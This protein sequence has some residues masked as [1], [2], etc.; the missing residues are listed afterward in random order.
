MAAERVKVVVRYR[1]GRIIKGNTLDFS[2]GKA[3]FHLYP[4]AAAGQAAEVAVSDLKAVFF[5][6]DFAGNPTHEEQKAFQSDARSMGRKIEVTFYDGEVLL[7]TTVGYDPKRSGFF[8]L[9]ADPESNNLK[10][11]AVQTAVQAVRFL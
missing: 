6:R 8:M 9:P 4:V 7:G 5:V 3:R 10:I 2:P 1:D 11:F